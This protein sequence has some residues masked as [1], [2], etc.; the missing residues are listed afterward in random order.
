MAKNEHRQP[1]GVVHTAAGQMGETQALRVALW[2]DL[3][4]GA[5]DGMVRP[6]ALRRVTRPAAHLVIRNEKN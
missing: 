5:R 6:D 1:T 4:G 2:D 3:R